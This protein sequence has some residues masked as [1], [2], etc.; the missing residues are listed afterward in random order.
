MAEEECKRS[1]ERG[2]LLNARLGDLA[3]DRDLEGVILLYKD[4]YV[5]FTNREMTPCLWPPPPEYQEQIEQ[6]KSLAEKKWFK[7]FIGSVNT[8]P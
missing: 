8:R 1:L 4:G 6:T 2:S 5:L 7:G 3:E